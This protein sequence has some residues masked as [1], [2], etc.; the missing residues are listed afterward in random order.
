M[1]KKTISLVLILSM[2]LSS[3][4]PAF[5][6]EISD[7]SEEVL[8]VS[9]EFAEQYPSGA[10]SLSTVSVETH[11]YSGRSEINVIRQGGAEGNMEVTVKA[12]DVSAKIDEDYSLS[13]PG[14][15]FSKKINGDKDTPTLLENGSTEVVSAEGTTPT[16]I[17]ETPS[18]IKDSCSEITTSTAIKNIGLRAVR[19]QAI[20]NV[21]DREKFSVPDDEELEQL[22]TAA[23]AAQN[24]YEEA[25]GTEFTLSFADG[26]RVKSFNLDI[27]DD[28]V[29]EAQE[30]IIF[31]IMGVTDGGSVGLQKEATVNII[32]DE[33]YE[34][35]V[36][37]FESE[38]FTADDETAKITL[39]RTEGVNYYAGAYISSI[40]DSARP[41]TDYTE[42]GQKILFIPG[43]KELSIEIPIVKNESEIDKYFHVKLE[44]DKSCTVSGDATAEVVIPKKVSI[45]K[46]S[47]P[48]GSL[49][50]SSDGVTLGIPKETLNGDSD[51]VFK[52]QDGLNHGYNTSEKDWWYEALI[53]HNCQK[54]TV[55]LAKSY[56]VSRLDSVKAD[57][58]LYKLHKDNHFD[59]KI[60]S[61]FLSKTNYE[62]FG[63]PYYAPHNEQLLLDGHNGEG[64]GGYDDKEHAKSIKTIYSKDW[65]IA[66]TSEPVN[67]EFQVSNGN[68]DY[69][70]MRIYSVEVNYKHFELS[71]LKPE[72]IS[73]YTFDFSKTTD[74]YKEEKVAPGTIDITTADGQSVK[75][76]YTSQDYTFNVVTNGV[77][78]G[79][80]LKELLLS[81]G[82]FEGAKDVSYD[83]S[84]NTGK[85]T[86]DH[87]W[88][89]KN[90][91]YIAEKGGDSS[92][93]LLYVQPVFERDTAT[94]NVSMQENEKDM[95]GIL[96]VINHENHTELSRTYTK[97]NTGSKTLHVRDK[98]IL[99]GIGYNGNVVSGYYVSTA[100]GG[101]ISEVG[102]EN[103]GIYTV[104][105]TKNVNISPI[106]GARQINI[107][108]DPKDTSKVQGT[109]T[110]GAQGQS[111]DIPLGNIHSGQVVDFVSIPP[112]GY[113]AVWKNRTGDKNNDGVLS[114]D[115]V[116]DSNGN[117]YRQYDYD[118][119][120]LL[121]NQY[122]IPMYGDLFSYKV[123]QPFPIF[124]Y[125]YEPLKTDGKSLCSGHVSGAV[126]TREY[127]IR[128]GI[129]QDKDNNNK[130]V[131]KIVPVGGAAVKMG[132][133]YD[134]SN[135][136]A[137]IGYGSSTSSNGLFTF[138][139]SN[140]K[141]ANYVFSIDYDG[142]SYIDSINPTFSSQFVIPLFTSME[143]LSIEGHPEGG[144][145]GSIV[146]GSV[147]YIKDKNVD[148]VLET[149]S[150]ENGVVVD[151]ADFKIYSKD[152]TLIS[153]KIV[154][155]SGNKAVYSA[156][157]NSFSPNDNMTVQ[158]IDQDNNKSREY[159]TGFKFIPAMKATTLLPSFAAPCEKY[160]PIIESVMGALDLGVVE[161]E[162][163][164]NLDDNITINTT[165]EGDDIFNTTIYMGVGHDF[166][167]TSKEL[168]NTID[169]AKKDDDEGEKAK[170]EIKDKNDSA[171]EKKDSN[172]KVKST[173]AN[174]LNVK[175]SLEMNI[176]Y[177]GK[178]KDSK[179]SKDS[180]DYPYYF[181]NLLLMVTMKDSVSSETRVVLPIGISIALK[182][183]VGGSVTGFIYITPET[184]KGESEPVRVYANEYGN[185]PYTNTDAT[186]FNSNLHAEG[187]IILEPT[188]DVDVNTECGVASID[189]DGHATFNLK[190]TTGNNN[191]GTVKLG[192]AISVKV[193]GFEV[194][195]KEY[196]E[197]DCEI[198]LFDN[199]SSLMAEMFGSDA[200]AQE[201][202]DTID[203]GYLNNRSEWL[204]DTDNLQGGSSSVTGYTEKSL[205]SGI[206]PY[207]DSQMMR[208]DEDSLLMVFV[209]DDADRADEN[210]SAIYYC[211]SHDNGATFSKPEMLAD[212]ETLDSR[213]RLENLGDRILC[214]YSSM[215]SLIMDN[216]TMEEVLEANGLEM[217]F[218]N[219]STYKFSKPVDVTKYTAIENPK[220]KG[221]L[222]GD[223]YSDENGNAVYDEASG[224]VMIIYTK[225][226]YTSDADREFKVQDLFGSYSTIAYMIYDTKTDSFLPYEASDYPSS[227]SDEEKGQW[228]KDWYGQ[229]FLDTKIVDSSLPGG[230][231]S[232]PLVYDLTTETKNG[233]AYI[234]YTVDMDGDMT[235]MNDR[236]IYFKTYDFA[237]NKFSDSTK[238][239]DIYDGCPELKTDGKPQ[240]V[241]YN[242]E[243]F[244][245]Y[246]SDTAIN[247]YN[248]DNISEELKSEGQ[249]ASIMPNVALEYNAENLPTDD[250]KVLVGDD[251]K[252]Y[253]VW[254]EETVRLADG[255]EP[256]SQ[257]SLKSEN[258]YHENQIY[259]SV[260]HQDFSK[261]SDD[262]DTV[263]VEADD[264]DLNRIYGKWSG[265]VLITEGPGNYDDISASV[266][267]NG[268]IIIAA[269]KS[270]EVLL[271]DSKNNLR[272]ENPNTAQLVALSLTP[273]AKVNMEQ[274]IITYEPAYPAPGDTVNISVQFSNSG[275][276]PLLNPIVDFYKVDGTTE[277][278]I[279][280]AK[281]L[282]PVFGGCSD[283]LSTEWTAP[284]NISNIKIIAKL[285]SGDEGAVIAQSEK[286]F[287]YDIVLQYASLNLEYVAKNY[288]RA[289]AEVNNSGNQPLTGAELVIK[290]VDS[291][292]N[293]HELKR[294]ALDDT[295]QANDMFTIDDSFE[296]TN[297]YL[298]D[299]CA[300]IEVSIE[301]DGN[302][303]VKQTGSVEKQ[304][305]G[306]LGNIIN[307]VDNIKMTQTELNI[308]QGSNATAVTNIY[309]TEA[310]EKNNIVYVSSDCN[311]ASVNTEGVITA[312]QTGSAVITAYAVPKVNVSSQTLD[313]NSIKGDVLD[314]L[315][316]ED[317]KNCSVKVNVSEKQSDNNKDKDDS[318]KYP[319]YEETTGSA[320]IT[321]GSSS[322][323][324]VTDKYEAKFDKDAI[325]SLLNGAKKETI[326]MSITALESLE[327]TKM[328]N[329]SLKIGEKVVTKLDKGS[330]RISIP[331]DLKDNEDP[332]AVVVYFMTKSGELKADPKSRYEDGKII[333]STSNFTKFAI[334][335]NYRE[336]TDVSKNAW[337]YDAV[338]FLSSRGIIDGIGEKLFAP[339]K[340]LTR[341]EFAKFIAL[342]FDFTWSG[343]KTE[344]A[345]VKDGSWYESYVG[346]LFEAGIINGTG[347]GAFGTG[348]YITR[349]DMIKILYAVLQKKGIS[350]NKIRDYN[351]FDDDDST[352]DYAA[353]AIKA[354]Y[355]AGI[356]NG[357]GN[358]K[359]APTENAPRS[360]IAVILEK[361]LKLN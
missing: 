266:M 64:E 150:L 302:T 6:S 354:L 90:S 239:S 167:E 308:Q 342:S 212:D 173:I 121:D 81:G 304:I 9:D 228:D 274:D 326:K 261:T 216:M 215:D 312:L 19:E 276:M 189:L 361:A 209:D 54:G 92:T 340:T 153:E 218:F 298:T 339:E 11:E 75:D 262:I 325:D 89:Y 99:S 134:K 310:S 357:I 284:E 214:L 107:R 178:D 334:G 263:S 255:V 42:V 360:N 221:Q 230:V 254:T 36:I 74:N 203:R 244:L 225:S 243:M 1:Y 18:S 147:V 84:D 296:L 17:E 23:S 157:L 142:V 158:L 246:N 91:S 165:E 170:E 187:G 237:D 272:V 347:N 151:K 271:E 98:V 327:K 61:R 60:Y 117:P 300:D 234:A 191:K 257:E 39:I 22:H 324:I 219:K 156:N 80:H 132:G 47:L 204:G 317:C 217:A 332:N 100:S 223:Y 183:T 180:K 229:R 28:D 155:V 199:T 242:N 31:V 338:T 44:P 127:D 149:A 197:D 356:I 7:F 120:K 55:W 206:Y 275:L 355:E 88:L 29:P 248:L 27:I 112:E 71:I 344:F 353:S 70:A 290:R 122:K 227:L 337:Y 232:D 351:G 319:E 116:Y 182:L 14:F 192:G 106:F 252:L 185:F 258:S 207:P 288:Y 253:L 83:M 299:G 123:N 328:Y 65:P 231:L 77:K 291:E 5:A 278:L 309:P 119:D 179:D 8:R 68:S 247:Y 85:L 279:G 111:V 233:I 161:T 259:A 198:S 168:I 103:A 164:K 211:V 194:Y 174:N 321:D 241:M 78:E 133:S 20:G 322:A 41:E 295:K 205:M 160:I 188:I 280:T 352:A 320:E 38:S 277:T 3:I 292:G 264:T 79:Y 57:I 52:G 72:P 32:D 245:F 289:Y 273:V 163:K 240:L 2:V 26:E 176:K 94:L 126:V 13:V 16:A 95:G 181:V 115:E 283:V 138:D 102:S 59:V 141:D 137:Q 250:Y 175:V 159:K 172:V 124:Y 146:S 148:F 177:D 190:F 307:E 301:K 333:F 130:Y 50:S 267:K 25:A 313:G 193:L 82:Q 125:S 226:D 330:V 213:P 86:I 281:G 51:F 45:K 268:N 4:T 201:S 341:E 260:F 236:D 69:A 15:I 195:D 33:D 235:T 166:D 105:L 87:D 143:T 101:P 303:L 113:T 10:F 43:Q 358:S 287:P 346:A 40:S 311:V 282:N 222:L 118:G 286:E 315:A 293:L 305:S 145:D 12:V 316:L 104:T 21:S 349:Q 37:K 56:Y 67:I 109:I 154:P 200:S 256:G 318:N 345:D 48:L 66:E 202:F 297:E 336:F 73:E 129:T 238:I 348:Q 53:E 58:M 323:S 96:G 270:E 210:R 269:K 97:D 329:L 224:K 331:Y 136:D 63:I 184:I 24:F 76:F 144:E 139:V 294:V 306:M 62:K 140:L 220:V 251:G 128:H 108:R 265:K 46:N 285:K 131:D 350:L 135:P 162:A 152:G 34:E 249:D 171:K 110:Y 335:N 314:S 343:K 196:D 49:S 93:C 114:G 186:S 169:K 30:Q 35:P 208:I 359:I